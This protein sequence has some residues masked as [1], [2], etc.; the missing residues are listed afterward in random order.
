MTNLAVA[1]ALIAAVAFADPVF[2]VDPQ[3]GLSVIAEGIREGIECTITWQRADG[4]GPRVSLDRPEGGLPDVR[5][6][7][8]SPRQE[9][10][11]QVKDSSGNNVGSQDY[12]TVTTGSTGVDEYDA[13]TPFVQFHGRP[14]F[15][16]FVLDQGSNLVGVNAEGWVVWYLPGGNGA[17]DQLP[18]K[19]DY[20]IVTM[21]GFGTLDASGLLELTPTGNKIA[22]KTVKGVSHEARVDTHDSDLVLTVGSE[23]RNVSIEGKNHQI[24]GSTI[25]EWNRK[26]GSVKTLYNLFDFYDPI[27][28]YGHCSGRND[29]TACRPPKE[30]TNVLFH[31]QGEDWTHANSVER[32]TRNNY[33]MSV[34]HLSSVVSFHADG[35]GI[36]W[37]MSG[38]GIKPSK[39]PAAKVLDYA[40]SGERQFMEHCARQLSNGNVILFDNG[41]LRQP[42]FTRFSEYEIDAERGTAKLVWQF[43]PMRNATEK[44]FAFHAGS[45]ER[46]A[47]G[48]TVG[49]LS[50]D[51]SRVGDN[52]THAIFEAN[53]KGEE[54]AR[55]LV[56]QIAGGGKGIQGSGYRGL[57]LGTIQGEYEV[58]PGVTVVV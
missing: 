32:G 21:Q 14:T 46:L 35:S 56:P 17:W 16:M 23:L 40:T 26:E 48:N 13:D 36:Q 5:L 29:S 33:I 22:N 49:A 12:Y 57:P 2:K 51:N 34:R 4:V 31:G 10:R 58:K 18:A 19:D 1:T 47:N 50:C 41:D 42:P 30:D 25:V 11:F 9:Y 6:F 44:M 8:F 7:R 54:V 43:L 20:N 15:E 52:C 39:A 55:A 37:V 3:Y 38:E 24:S 53:S 45:V 28:D 27:T